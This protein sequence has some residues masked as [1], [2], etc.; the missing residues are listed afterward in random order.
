MLRRSR[1]RSFL[2]CF[3]QLRF[4]EFRSFNYDNRN[5]DSISRQLVFFFRF[6]SA[7]Q[8][9]VAIFIRLFEKFFD[10]VEH[11]ENKNK[12]NA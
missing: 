10:V 5:C 2:S 9:V 4:C 6:V 8:S 1:S 12:L 7:F 11:D 3:L